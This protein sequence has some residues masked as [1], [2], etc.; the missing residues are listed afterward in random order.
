MHRTTPVV[1]LATA[2]ALT[3]SGCFANPLDQLT[4]NL[5][6]GGVEQI[7]EGQ[8]GVDVDLGGAGATLPESFPAGMP[9]PNGELLYSLAIDD[10]YAL[11]YSIPDIAV[12]GALY[13]EL[14][15]AGF[16]LMSEVNMGEGASGRVYENDSYNVSAFAATND[17][18]TVSLQYTV[19]TKG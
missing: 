5:I 18:G 9:T 6:E 12:T 15:G 4:E 7:I 2:A 17:D 10:S 14:E 11:T 3:L 19:A 1:V 13:A 8:T 16:A